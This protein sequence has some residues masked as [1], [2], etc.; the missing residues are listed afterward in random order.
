MTFTANTPLTQV[1][2]TTLPL[3]P[4]A[5]SSKA[6]RAAAAAA[7][8]LGSFARTGH[9]LRTMERVAA[10]LGAN[11]AALL[12]GETGTGKTTTLAQLASMVGAYHMSVVVVGQKLYAAVYMPW[13]GLQHYSICT[14]HSGSKKG[15]G[16][17]STMHLLR[18]GATL[19]T[20]CFVKFSTT[21]PR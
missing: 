20:E 10:A 16:F 19:H 3:A 12:V 14:G 5:P 1:G 21:F 17:D 6:K 18:N 7:I 9:A 11:E 13:D 15:H 2:R 8:G 4:G